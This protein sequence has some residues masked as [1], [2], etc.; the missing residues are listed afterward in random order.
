MS[1]RDAINAAFQ[2]VTPFNPLEVREMLAQH[3]VHQLFGQ[4]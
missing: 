1:D 2:G 3:L 4:A